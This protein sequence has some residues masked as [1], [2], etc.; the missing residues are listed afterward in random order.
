MCTQLYK[1]ANQRKL[2]CAFGEYASNG[3]TE[4]PGKTGLFSM[5][6]PCHVLPCG[7]GS[8][9]EDFMGSAAKQGKLRPFGPVVY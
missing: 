5:H 4:A 1:E 8:N 2:M 3:L 7:R 9:C 6:H